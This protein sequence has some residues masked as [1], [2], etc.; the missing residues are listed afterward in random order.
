MILIK[1]HLLLFE[2]QVKRD[3]IAYVMLTQTVP[4]G[5]APT[6]AQADAI[7]GSKLA[8]AKGKLALLALY[9]LVWVGCR[10]SDVAKMIMNC[11]IR[12]VT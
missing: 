6:Q 10:T 7:E 8:V 3:Q 1:A 2:H 12:V 4:L 9:L 5:T 11:D